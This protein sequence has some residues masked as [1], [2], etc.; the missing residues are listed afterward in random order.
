[1]TVRLRPHH[2]L[3]MLTY[4]GKGYSTAFV[5][6]Y[7]QLV[8]RIGDGEDI[9]VVAGPDDVCRPFLEGGQGHCLEPDVVNRDRTAAVSLTR[10]GLHLAEGAVVRLDAQ[11]LRQMREAFA[12][13]GIRAACAGCQW[14][15]LCD[16]VAQ[17][18]YRDTRLACPP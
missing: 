1:M 9:A 18:G 7:D 13:G 11:L 14:S 16:G 6:N 12:A 4:V 3:C 17:G 10:L 2:L 15:P 8:A 5:E